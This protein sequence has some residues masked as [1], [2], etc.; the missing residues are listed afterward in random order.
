M[1]PPTWAVQATRTG[2]VREGEETFIGLMGTP[3]LTIESTRLEGIP[4]QLGVGVFFSRLRKDQL[5]FVVNL[6]GT[7]LLSAFFGK[8]SPSS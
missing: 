3:L 4:I 5:A 1:V 7:S 8:L 6:D 2:G